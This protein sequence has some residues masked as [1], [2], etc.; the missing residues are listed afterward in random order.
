MLE[1]KREQ[2]LTLANDAELR[3]LPVGDS[4]LA[5]WVRSI[6]QTSRGYG[7][8]PEPLLERAGLDRSL[9][10][11]PGA[12][13]PATQV[14]RLWEQLMSETDDPLIGMRC[15]QEMQVATLHSLGLAV[16]T[17][18][19]L[20]QVLD[21]VARYAKIIS[22]TMDVS[23]SHNHEGTTLRLR[24]LKGTEPGGSASLAMLAFILRQ[25]NSLSHHKVT[26]TAVGVNLPNLAQKDRERLDEHFGVPVD[27]AA[28]CAY[29]TFAYPDTIEPYASAN[30]ILREVT[31]ELS[32]AYLNRVRQASFASRA[33]EVM[34]KLLVNG[35]P[36][37]KEVAD[38][39]HLSA[40]TLQRRLE[41]EG[42]SSHAA[43]APRA[44]RGLLC[45]TSRPSSPTTR[46]RHARP[47]R[48]AHHRNLLRP[49]FF[50]SEQLQPRLQPL[51]RNG[52]GRLPKAHAHGS[53]L[54]GKSAF[55]TRVRSL[56]RLA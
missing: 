29:I 21:L 4:I 42:V 10:G 40:R 49:R 9:L 45:G 18:R 26:P 39:L 6:C 14:R 28:E 54:S 36:K 53:D 25:A 8:E 30:A 51:V 27:T 38:A 41:R 46:P 16:V 5:A 47:Q 44:G 13:F 37:I 2:L 33:E 11:V 34:T 50:R 56:G 31:E 52:P 17:S 23:L 48:A 1:E 22:S 20:S 19:S 32:I 7:I 55:S 43:A 24:T 35:Q 12:R 15:G 3:E